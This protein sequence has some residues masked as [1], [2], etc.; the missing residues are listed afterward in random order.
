MVWAEIMFWIML[1][2]L[3]GFVAIF[4]AEIT[5]QKWVEANQ[6]AFRGFRAALHLALGLSAGRAALTRLLRSGDLGGGS[7]LAMGLWI[8]TALGL[9]DWLAAEAIATFQVGPRRAK[10]V[11]FGIATVFTAVG[12]WF[13][14]TRSGLTPPAP[15]APPLNT[16]PAPLTDANQAAVQKGLA[17]LDRADGELK[18]LSSGAVSAVTKDAADGIFAILL[19]YSHLCAEVLAE[20]PKGHPV[21]MPM[22]DSG[23]SYP[24]A[25]RLRFLAL[26]APEALGGMPGAVEYAELIADRYKVPTSNFGQV[27]NAVLREARRQRNQAADAAGLPNNHYA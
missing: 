19:E 3:G 12:A 17:L 1:V 15:L 25:I 14:V 23:L 20:V 26:G 9:G 4:V 16:P 13:A 27:A 8:G 10:G 21:R 22:L 2:F 6:P 18:L 24:I 7:A 5:A 11:W